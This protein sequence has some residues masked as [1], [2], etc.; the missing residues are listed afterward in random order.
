[1]NGWTVITSLSLRSRSAM[2]LGCRDSSSHYN[3]VSVRGWIIRFAVPAA[4]FLVTPEYQN[5]TQTLIHIPL[6]DGPLNRTC[7]SIVDRNDNR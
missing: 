7:Y 5:P 2:S 6:D 4:D 1:M 3:R